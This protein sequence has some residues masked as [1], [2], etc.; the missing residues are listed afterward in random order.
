[1]K[2]VTLPATADQ[3]RMIDAQSSAILQQLITATPDQV[4]AWLAAHVTDLAS[5][6]TVLKALA[7]GLRYVYLKETP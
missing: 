6:R 1:M 5:A 7:L 3:Q 4:D 2:I